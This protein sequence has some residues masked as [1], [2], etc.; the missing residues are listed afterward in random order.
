MNNQTTIKVLNDNELESTLT[1]LNEYVIPIKGREYKLITIEEFNL[2]RKLNRISANDKVSLG[3]D[4]K[5]LLVEYVFNECFNITRSTSYINVNL[6]YGSDEQSSKLFAL[7]KQ[8]IFD[9]SIKYAEIP[10]VD[11]LNSPKNSIHI[12]H[13]I[14]QLETMQ[15]DDYIAYV[16]AFLAVEGIGLPSYETLDNW[17]YNGVPLVNDYFIDD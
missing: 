17:L 13:Y 9:E 12:E 7:A 8:K 3:S 1:E 11:Y 16:S 5:L 15:N 4:C 10:I 6:C 14:K 2:L